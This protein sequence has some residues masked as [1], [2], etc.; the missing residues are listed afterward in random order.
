MSYMDIRNNKT[1]LQDRIKRFTLKATASAVFALNAEAVMAVNCPPEINGSALA[2]V[3][4]D[5]NGISPSGNSV[6][7]ENGGTVGGI[8]MSNYQPTDSHITVNAGGLVNNTT[9]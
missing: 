3:I 2:G 8:L 5:F 6:T 4:C 7:V 9:G 1:I